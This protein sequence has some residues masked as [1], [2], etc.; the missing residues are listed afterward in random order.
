MSETDPPLNL[1][2]IAAFPDLAAAVRRREPAITAR[3]AQ[4]VREVLPK[5]DDLTFAQLR[6]DVP[7]ILGQIADSLQR[8]G[9]RHVDNLLALS[10]AH[11]TIRFHQS[12]DLR[13]VLLEFDL[14]RPILLEEVI[15][16][17]GRK[18]SVE[19]VVAVNVGMDLSVRQSVLA[20]AQHQS[21]QLSAATE[22]QSKYLSFLSHDLRGGLN[23]V[24]LMIEVLKREL[25][26]ETRLAGTI[27]DLDSMRRSLLETVAT[28]DRFLHAERFRKGKVQVRNVPLNLKNICDEIIAHF[29]YQAQEKGLQLEAQVAGDVTV[30]SDRELLT[31][32]LQNLVSNAIKYTVKGAVRLTCAPNADPGMLLSILDEGPGIDADKL[33]EI[34]TPFTRGQ[35]YGQSGVG[36]GLFIARQAA[37]LL[38]AKLWAESKPGKGSTF[39]LELPGAPAKP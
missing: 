32:V 6:D 39:F 17:I 16:Q 20:F 33:S 18:L 2:T 24:F 28:M 11:G 13:E 15:A 4:I 29:I 5:A 8:S 1:L 14:L 9:V 27:H 21:A 31:L 36:L 26:Q 23:G 38:G 34:F 19:E 10:E 37:D 7:R 30:V 3:W 25:A 35:T 22:S 12:Y